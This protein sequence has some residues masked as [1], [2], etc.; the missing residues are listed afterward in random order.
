MKKEV[1]P[2]LNRAFK[3]GTFLSLMFAP[4]VA[5]A[6]NVAYE[7]EEN[8]NSKIIYSDSVDVAYLKEVKLNL[9][10]DWIGRRVFQMD[11][12]CFEVSQVLKTEDLKLD[13]K[14]DAIKHAGLPEKIT[15]AK[16]KSS[17]GTVDCDIYTSSTIRLK[18]ED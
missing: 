3:L 1:T 16:M 18:I 5:F 15:L 17:V 10:D 14:D 2:S 6:S 13:S 12:V 11:G 8:P 4:Y 9:T 7:L